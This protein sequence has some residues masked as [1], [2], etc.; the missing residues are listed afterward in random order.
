VNLIL[1]IS[2]FLL[3][4]L[5]ELSKA[6]NMKRRL[7]SEWSIQRAVRYKLL[8]KTKKLVRE[9]SNELQKK[10]KMECT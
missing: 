6:R 5:T 10:S 3:A 1:K 9:S 7:S 4:T 2:T 8:A